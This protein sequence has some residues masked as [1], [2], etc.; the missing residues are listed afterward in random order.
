MIQNYLPNRQILASVTRSLLTAQSRWA[1]V[2]MAFLNVMIIGGA[3]L[4]LGGG[5]QQF[6]DTAVSVLVVNLHILWIW[7][8]LRLLAL[9]TPVAARLV[10][11]CV[12]RLRVTALWLWASIALAASL[13]EVPTEA[14]CCGLCWGLPL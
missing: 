9:N 13:L 3:G 8:A 11:Q 10:P 7:F 6:I 2:A 12:M 5:L 4:A 1:Y 14:A